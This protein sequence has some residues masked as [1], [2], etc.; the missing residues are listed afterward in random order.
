VTDERQHLIDTVAALFAAAKANDFAAFKA[1]ASPD[2]FIHENGERLDASGVFHLIDNAQRNGAVFDWN[3]CDPVV[4]IDGNLAS[5]AYLN[6]GSVTRDNERQAVTWLETAIL[7]RTDGKWRI[8]FMSSMR[9][10]N[11]GMSAPD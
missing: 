9:A 6:R 1:C 3:I 10:V 2:F 7:T 4:H 8:A 5:I 11:A